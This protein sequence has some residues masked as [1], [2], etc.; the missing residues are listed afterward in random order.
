MSDGANSTEGGLSYLFNYR[1][2]LSETSAG[3]RMKDYDRRIWATTR[4]RKRRWRGAKA[5]EGLSGKLKARSHARREYCNLHCVWGWAL[6]GFID[7]GREETSMGAGGWMRAITLQ[8]AGPGTSRRPWGLCGICDQQ[9][10]LDNG[11]RCRRRGWL[12]P[13]SSHAPR[14]PD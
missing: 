10:R 3:K 11:W 14:R 4:T 13:W 2:V 6:G 1:N 8:S 7:L 12:H 5:E 9:P